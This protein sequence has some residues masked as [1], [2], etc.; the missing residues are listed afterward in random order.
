MVNGGKSFRFDFEAA[1]FIGI[2]R[3]TACS[4]LSIGLFYITFY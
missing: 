3:L 4:L 1:I 2:I